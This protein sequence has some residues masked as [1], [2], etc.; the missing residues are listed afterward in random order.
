MH[1]KNFW[2]YSTHW[3]NCFKW[4]TAQS[5]NESR[6]GLHWYRDGSANFA[7]KFERN[8]SMGQSGRN[9]SD[10]W[11][12]EKQ[13][14]ICGDVLEQNERNP[15][16]QWKNPLTPRA[17]KAWL[18]KSTFKTMLVVLFDS[19]GF[20]LEEWDP[21]RSRVNQHYYK[22]GMHSIIRLILASAGIKISADI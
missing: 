18:S 14:K 9:N 2:K 1:I 7:W 21:E 12:K 19:K 3:T 15:H 16:L 22:L 11:S 8:K 20:I 4:L 6:N 17:K 13:E 5:K 10:S